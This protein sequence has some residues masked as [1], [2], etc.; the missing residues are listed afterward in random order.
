MEFSLTNPLVYVA[1][2]IP[3][4]G[5]DLSPYAESASASDSERSQ[6]KI[7][8]LVFD[9]PEALL[10]AAEV[11]A[12]AGGTVRSDWRDCLHEQGFVVLVPSCKCI[13]NP[14]AARSRYFSY[15]GVGSSRNL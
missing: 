15:K 13:G 7:A 10:S 1:Q 11:P 14:L 3:Y 5:R 12:D 4:S 9:E 2:S 8:W 6:M